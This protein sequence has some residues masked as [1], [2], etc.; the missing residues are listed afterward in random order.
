MSA[1]LARCPGCGAA[2]NEVE[3]C[4]ADPGPPTDR[5]DPGSAAHHF[6][7]LVLRCT[8]DTFLNLAPIR[9]SGDPAHE[10]EHSRVRG[11][12]RK[13]FSTLTDPRRCSAAVHSFSTRLSGG[14]IS[15][16]SGRAHEGWRRFVSCFGH[17]D[18]AHRGRA[19]F[20][21]RNGRARACS[22]SCHEHRGCGQDERF[23]HGPPPLISNRCSHYRRYRDP[24][25]SKISKPTCR[26]IM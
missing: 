18:L 25:Y 4:A 19:F 26:S 5:D 7:S 8:R 12:E 13:R 14:R 10:R 15:R 21:L 20:G 22:R 17:R 1:K 16:S 6:A 11:N 24:S 2:R 9:E 3:R 23:A